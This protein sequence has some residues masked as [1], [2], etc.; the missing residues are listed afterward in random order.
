MC[1]T[2]PM[3]FSH[4]VYLAQAAHEFILYR[5][6]LLRKE[7][8]L[9]LLQSPLVSLTRV[10]HGIVIDDFFLFCLCQKLADRTL[11]LVLDAYAAAGFVVKQSKVVRPTSAP[12]KIIGFDID[13]ARG[14]ISLP[15][16]SQLS[17]LRST[18]AV[19]HQ[20]TVTGSQL[21]HIIGRWT[22][23]MMLRRSSLAVLQHCYRYC[24]Q[25]QLRR[26]TL[27]P[28]VR[29]ELCMLVSLLP[30]LLAD[31]RA[32]FFRRA[33]A[34][35]ASELAGGVVSTPLTPT[36]SGQ[37]WPLCSSRH[38]AVQQTQCNAQRMRGESATAVSL[39]SEFDSFYSTVSSAPWRTLISKPWA[40]VE[41]IN[42]LE[43]R[44]ALLSVHWV[45]SYPSSL[46][47]R[48]YLLLDSTV[49]FFSLW[50][51]RSSSP[52]LLLVLRKISALLLASGLS[53]LP[54]WVPSAVNPADAPSRLIDPCPRGRANL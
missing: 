4:A 43:L 40:G 21:S 5:H 53:L 27:W 2:M 30:L 50:K 39:S 32:P 6:G 45:L 10:I 20:P 51:G 48:V 37:L 44:A 1:L 8:N 42:A 19:L 36:L 18:I 11:Q 24:R 13:G 47:R 46:N 25:A 12:V 52:A 15:A 23:V 41:H 49:A 9:L 16:D 54:G 22:W 34:S 29:R 35:D 31:L 28:T 14:E 17:L 38:H 3:G 7:D 26:F 33:I